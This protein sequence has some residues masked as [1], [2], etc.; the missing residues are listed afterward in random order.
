M[1]PLRRPSPSL[2]AANPL[3]SMKMAGS[4]GLESAA[5]CRDLLFHRLRSKESPSRSQLTCLPPEFLTADLLVSLKSCS[6]AT[7]L[8]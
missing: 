1:R 5:R 7:P 4:T 2:M 3:K 8:R 6:G